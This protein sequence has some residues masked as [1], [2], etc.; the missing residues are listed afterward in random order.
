MNVHVSL[1]KRER[2]REREREIESEKY[3]GMSMLVGIPNKRRLFESVD[4]SVKVVVVVVCIHAC[5]CVCVCVCVYVCVCIR[6]KTRYDETLKKG[7]RNKRGE[8]RERLRE[9]RIVHE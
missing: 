8:V 5:V 3:V 7:G 9:K 1:I 2:E 4:M 6:R